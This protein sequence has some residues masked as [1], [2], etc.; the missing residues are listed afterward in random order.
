VHEDGDH[1][2]ARGSNSRQEL[3]LATGEVESVR[4]DALR[5]RALA[6]AKGRIP[7]DNNRNLSGSSCKSSLE[8]GR[9]YECTQA[10][11]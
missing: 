8:E 3:E 11:R 5:T 1:R 6:V 4:V 2:G 10:H 7:D 9:E